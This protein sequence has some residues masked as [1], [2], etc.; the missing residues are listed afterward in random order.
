MNSASSHLSPRARL[1]ADRL[2]LDLLRLRLVPEPLLELPLLDFLAR[3]DRDPEADRPLEDEPERLVEPPDEDRDDEP[4]LLLRPRD[5]PEP[6][7]D[8]LRDDDERLAARARVLPLESL[9][10]DDG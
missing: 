8:A 6:E 4:E 9:P 3:D 10:L 2:E 7:P 5:E 1:D